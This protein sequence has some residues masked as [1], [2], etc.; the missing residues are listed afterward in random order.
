MPGGRAVDHMVLS[1]WWERNQKSSGRMTSGVVIQVMP[2]VSRIPVGL[3]V[4]QHFSSVIFH[5]F[6]KFANHVVS[7]EV[8]RL[9]ITQRAFSLARRKWEHNIH[10]DIEILAKVMKFTLNYLYL[11]ASVS[12]NIVSRPSTESQGLSYE[13]SNTFQ[14]IDGDLHTKNSTITH[15]L[16]LSSNIYAKR[17]LGHLVL[18]CPLIWKHSRFHYF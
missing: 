2:E 4:A 11:S 5:L 6:L 14:C 3:F 17:E 16:H 9:P 15:H 1:G 13:V 10:I 8:R 7:E 12:I 18:L